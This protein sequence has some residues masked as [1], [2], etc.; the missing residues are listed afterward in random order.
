MASRNDGSPKDATEM[1]D[2]IEDRTSGES[3][4]VGELV[5]SVGR[6]AFGPLLILASL[7]ALL[8]T[9]AIPGMS[10]VT[11]AIMLTVSAQLLFGA[12]RVWL[13]RTIARWRM[14]RDRL[15]ANLDRVR[16]WDERLRFLVKER[17][18]ILLR[19]PFLNLVALAGVILSLSNF[20]LGPL[21]FG[22]FPAGLAFIV[23][24]A[25]LT[26]RDGLLVAVGIAL[27]AAGLAGALSIWPY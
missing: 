12:E 20:V 9:G 7:I 27:G 10:F 4:T 6:R 15:V 26:A 11:G 2:R 23:I 19:P 25:G 3:V 8:P 22:S 17:L 24:G 14:D 1:A 16:K 13:P 18:T 21:P 5:R